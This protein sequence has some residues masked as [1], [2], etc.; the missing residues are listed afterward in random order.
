MSAEFGIEFCIAFCRRIH[1]RFV[2]RDS[3]LFLVSKG[4]I[5]RADAVKVY[6]WSRGIVTT[7]F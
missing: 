7:N 5:M 1:V 2:R 6:W 4:K 3:V